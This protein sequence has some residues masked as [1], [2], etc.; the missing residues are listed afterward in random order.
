MKLHCAIALLFA[1]ALTL[2]GEKPRVAIIQPAH[3]QTLSSGLVLLAAEASD[4]DGRVDRV[5]YY[6]DDV[7]VAAVNDPPHFEAFVTVAPGR[8]LFRAIVYDD[9]GDW[10]RSAPSYFQVGGEN[11]VNLLRGPYLQLCNSTSVVVR[12][13]TDWPTNSVVLFTTNWPNFAA[14]SNRTR[15]SE[16]EVLISGLMPDTAYSYVIGSATELYEE[17]APQLFRAAPTNTRPVTVWAI[18]DF[19]SGQTGQVAVLNSFINSDDFARA[20]LW[21]MLGDN[22]YECG[23]DEE[24]QTKVFNIYGEVLSRLPVWPSIG[25]HDAAEPDHLGR[26]PY[27]DIF[28]L[29][30]NA[31]SG[32]VPSLTERYYSFDYANVNF[33]A[34]DSYTSD[35]ST[36]GA[37]LNWL[38]ADLAQTDQDWIV[39]YW[40][41]PPYSSGSHNSEIDLELVQMREQVLP[42]LE[43]YGTDLVLTGHCHDYE[44]SYLIHGHYGFN[45]SFTDDMKLDGS[46]GND[47]DEGP[48]RK[49]PGGLG[50][51]YVVCGLSGEGGGDSPFFSPLKHC[52]VRNLG[53][54]GSLL[55]NFDHLRLHAKLLRPDGTFAD[56]FSIDKSA[57]KLNVV[58]SLNGIELTW[59]ASLQAYVLESSAVMNPNGW[60]T[61]TNS[62][63]RWGRNNKVT[64]GVTRTNQF[65]RLRAAP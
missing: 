27:L 59:P 24:Y 13:R 42:V 36:N 50:T 22:A 21:L 4:P 58:R 6:I 54:Q 2:L 31:E 51:V 44:R 40:H 8:H 9:R 53:G 57:P 45:N 38:R 11:P 3:G 47:D 14:V 17:N 37:M 7:F 20:D 25:N 62:I 28:S 33:V 65:F 30:A 63:S 10:R 16:H 64:L 48:Y 61:A 26:F 32:G 34:L 60:Q 46:L 12:W 41:H 35:R 5:E 29:P 23:L 15:T 19:G 43:A 52:N 1:F 49:P 56:H 39:A 55:L 18:G